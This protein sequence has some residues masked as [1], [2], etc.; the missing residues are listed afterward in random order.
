MVIKQKTVIRQATRED[1]P[2]LTRLL[3]LQYRNKFNEEYIYW[4]YFNSVNEN[5]IFCLEVDGTIGGMFGVLPKMLSNGMIGLQAADMLISKEFRGKGLFSEIAS[6][7]FS[8]F[9]NKDFCFVLPN[10][11]GKTA[12]EKSLEWDTVCKINEWQLDL[13]QYKNVSAGGK[14]PAYSGRLLRFQYSDETFQWRFQ[15]PLY[16]YDKRLFQDNNYAY[17]KTFFDALNEQE[18][19]D[20]V[21]TSSDSISIST[22]TAFLSELQHHDKHVVL[23]SWAMPGTNMAKNLSRLGFAEI[24]RERYLCISGEEIIVNQLKDP[25]RWDLLQSDTEFY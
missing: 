16:K 23:S 4:Q 24:E 6:S 7:A 20:I 18:F 25:Q 10:L 19:L 17:V 8:F 11:K 1:V 13:T 15:N 12:V 9:S 3:N 22:L 14:E 5:T 2:Q 21:Y